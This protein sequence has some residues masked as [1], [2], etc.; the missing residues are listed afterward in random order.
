MPGAHCWL[1]TK[2]WLWPSYH[3]CVADED[4]F[5]SAPGVWNHPGHKWTY[6]HSSKETGLY[7]C[8]Q[9]R[10]VTSQVPLK[11]KWKEG[12]GNDYLIEIILGRLSVRLPM[13]LSTFMLVLRLPLCP[14]VHQIICLFVCPCI[15]SSLPLPIRLFACLRSWPPVHHWPDLNPCSLLLPH[16]P[17]KSY[18]RHGALKRSYKFVSVTSIT[19]FP[20]L[21]RDIWCHTLKLRSTKTKH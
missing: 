19:T 9:E 13:C 15:C 16:P 12:K 6:Q 14:S 20:C 8:T 4:T 11:H 5:L 21:A 7:R 17:E 3:D 18:L 10:A 1:M 2:P